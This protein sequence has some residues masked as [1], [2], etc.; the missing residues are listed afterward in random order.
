MS[1]GTDE[2]HLTREQVGRMFET[3]SNW[4]RWGEDD[5]LGTL[6]LITAEHRRRAA[7][8]VREGRAVSLGRAISPTFAV[9]NPWPALHHMI[10]SGAGA[11][12]GFVGMTD[13]FGLAC[14]GFAVTHLDGLNHA[15]WNGKMY[16]GRAASSVTTRHG[17]RAGA[18]GRAGARIATRGLLV[19]VPALRGLPWLDL[20]DRVRPG[21]LDAWEAWSGIRVD[22]GDALV[23]STGRDS[24]RRERG[25]HDFWKE[26][27]PGLDA[28]CLPWLRERDVAVLVSDTGQDAMP[29]GYPDIPTPVHGVGIVAMGL[30]LL[31]N[32][33]LDELL[34]VC[35]EH[36]VWE[37][38]LCC[39]PL[40]VKGA[41]G[42][43]VTPVAI[44]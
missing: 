25:A 21:D 31:D 8:L 2:E 35:R 43:P 3:L 4:G 29:S 32:A 44:I 22:A 34:D 1:A 18:V 10:E 24:R 14:H 5:D 19:D 28:S 20:G 40:D 13:W 33:G 39:A 30:W 23:I 11:H 6:N 16:N 12:E 7:A 17:G 38:L 26:G 27:S 9:D 42:S 36:G 41:T 15:A 37:F